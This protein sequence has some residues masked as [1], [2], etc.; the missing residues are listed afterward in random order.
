MRVDILLV[1]VSI[2]DAHPN[3]PKLGPNWEEKTDI[4]IMAKRL[5]PE[6]MFVY[7]E[8]AALPSPRRPRTLLKDI[9]TIV[10][11]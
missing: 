3:P 8:G 2:P 10:D 1:A 9:V 4:E 6:H 7:G 11:L 5:K